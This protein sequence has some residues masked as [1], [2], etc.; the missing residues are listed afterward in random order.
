MLSFSG[1]P[2]ILC[3]LCSYTLRNA[4]YRLCLQKSLETS[5]DEEANYQQ[6]ESS[7][8]QEQHFKDDQ[9]G[10]SGNMPKKENG[11]IFAGDCVE[12]SHERTISDEDDGETLES[13]GH[14]TEETRNYI[15]Y[16][17]TKLKSV[18]KVSV[19]FKINYD[20]ANFSGTIKINDSISLINDN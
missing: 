15:Q 12:N 11:N 14:M 8:N 4:E 17:K 9:E 1:F 7:T 10:N 20:R 6:D 16:L 5:D 3:Y 18:T 13:L 2:F 19:C